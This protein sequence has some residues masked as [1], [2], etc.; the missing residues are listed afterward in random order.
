[1]RKSGVPIKEVRPASIAAELGIVKGD[2]LLSVNGAAV[3]DILEYKYLTTDEYLELEVEKAD[4]ECWIYE[5]EKEYDEDV[6]LVFEGIIDNPKS[7][8]NKCIFCFIDQLPQGMRETLYF[9]DDDTRLSFLQGNFVTL[10]NLKERDIDK[11]VRYRISPIQVSVHTTDPELR[12]RMLNNKN[13]G[14]I[15]GYLDKLKAGSIE[16]KAQIVLCPGVNDGENLEKTV[17]DLTAYHPELSCVAVVPVGLTKF[18]NRLFHLEPVGKKEAAAVIRQVEEMQQRYLE[19]YETRFIFLS[20][21]FYIL[22]EQELPGYDTYEAF[23]QLENGVGLIALLREEIA[24]SLRSLSAYPDKRRTLSIATGEYAAPFLMAEADKIM[25]KIQNLEIAVYPIANHFFGGDVKVS[26][27]LTGC[28]IISQLKGKPLGSR[29]LIPDNMLRQG[30]QV[31][32]D[33]KTVQDLERETGVPVIVCKEDGSD[34]ID[35]ILSI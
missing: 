23:S 7:C 9:K 6:G 30:E 10:T 2:K 4:G 16:V 12:T 20:D 13:A 1:M 25:E 8:H 28:D 29:L 35:K 22:A 19:T 21:E 33:D 15:T 17:H 18:R 5:L 24:N 14:K 31:F 32:L 11:I 26:G 3:L 27:L 34:L